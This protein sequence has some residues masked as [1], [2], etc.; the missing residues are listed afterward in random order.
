[1]QLEE[2][3]G[4]IRKLKHQNE[5]YEQQFQQFELVKDAMAT[6]YLQP[7]PTVGV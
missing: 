7:E 1:M 2:T 4:V 3:L 5:S 6:T